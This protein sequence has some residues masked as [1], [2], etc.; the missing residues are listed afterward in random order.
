VEWGVEWF[1]QEH[2]T[3][4]RFLLIFFHLVNG[5]QKINL[6]KFSVLAEIEA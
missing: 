6:K 1:C 3:I 4:T 5:L 2:D